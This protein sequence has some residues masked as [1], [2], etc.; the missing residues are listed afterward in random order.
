L[1][2]EGKIKRIRGFGVNRIEYY[3]QDMVSNNCTNKTEIIRESKL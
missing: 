2:K 3:Y 1:I